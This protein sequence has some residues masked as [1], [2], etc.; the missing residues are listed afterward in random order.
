MRKLRIF[1]MSPLV[2]SVG[3]LL[4]LGACNGKGETA[5]DMLGVS[6][7]GPDAFNVVSRPPL[8]VPP[9]FDLRPPAPTGTPGPGQPK[10]DD[11]ARGLITGDDAEPSN[12]LGVNTS[13][14]GVGSNSI[15]TAGERHLM[16]KFGATKTDHMIREQ[17]TNEQYLKKE[18]ES[19][20]N[21]V[22]PSLR[23]KKAKDELDPAVEAEKLR[24]DDATSKAVKTPPVPVKTDAD[25][26]AP[27]R[28]TNNILTIN[29][30]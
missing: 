8:S 20:L 29:G 7:S 6:R 9:E 3:A 18:D 24:A 30:D 19:W 11:V 26:S 5:Q 21:D 16:E 17:L 13:V 12:P 10:M 27:S 1:P 22:I 14:M 28:V 4:A 23:S 2:L 25:K 15:D